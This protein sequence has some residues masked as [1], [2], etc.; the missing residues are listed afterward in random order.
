[1]KKYVSFFPFR[2]VAI[3]KQVAKLLEKFNPSYFLIK[4]RIHCDMKI[5][6]NFLNLGQILIL[7]FPSGGTLLAWRVWIREENLVYDNIS[8]IDFLFS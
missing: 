4:L 8:N 3:E 1:L 2:R 5:V 6:V 7:H